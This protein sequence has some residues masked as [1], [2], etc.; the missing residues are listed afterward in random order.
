MEMEH[1]E[2]AAR[3]SKAHYTGQTIGA[4]LHKMPSVDLANG[5]LHIALDGSAYH[6]SFRRERAW[7]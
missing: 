4:L 2:T 1:R 5:R 3:I 7:S 6:C